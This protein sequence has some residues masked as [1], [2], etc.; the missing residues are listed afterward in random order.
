MSAKITDER[1]EFV[2][3]KNAP[4][5]IVCKY[6]VV[7]A[8]KV[9]TQSSEI[10]FAKF[11]SNCRLPKMKRGLTIKFAKVKE[12]ELMP[13]NVMEAVSKIGQVLPLY[14]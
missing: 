1:N 10:I 14:S 3:Y 9:R 6:R 7:I 12:Q 13:E 5:F 8:H 11:R 2:L 4:L